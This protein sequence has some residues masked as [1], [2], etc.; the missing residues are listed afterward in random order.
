MDADTGRIESVPTQFVAHVGGDHDHAAEAAVERDV[1]LALGKAR[2]LHGQSAPA[3]AGQAGQARE[4]APPARRPRAD[5][6]GEEVVFVTAH[7]VDVVVVHHADARPP[8]FEQR[9]DNRQI[10]HL[11]DIDHVGPEGLDRPARYARRVLPFQAP[12]F[13]KGGVPFLLAGPGRGSVQQPDDM[14]P[15]SQFLG[16]DLGIGFGTR[17]GAKTLMDV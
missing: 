16:R 17:Q 13:R 15:P 7:A 14:P 9:L 2:P 11:V 12:A 1:A 5:A 8:G 3:V 6:A 4:D 10:G